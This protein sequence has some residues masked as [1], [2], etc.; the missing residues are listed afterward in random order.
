[1]GKQL[2]EEMVKDCLALYLKYGGERHDLIEQD[3]HRLGW[4]SFKKGM[5]GDRGNGENYRAGLVN[6][7]RWDLVLKKHLIDLAT[8]TVAATSAE[9]LLV[10][11]E[12]I[13]DAAFQEIKTLGVRAS[14]DLIYQ[15]NLYSQNCIKILDKLDAARDNYANFVFFLKHLL[16][17]APTISPSLTRELCDAEDALLDW[18][19]RQFVVEDERPDEL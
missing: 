3:M 13:R 8:N 19:E 16:S 10:E 17:A 4:S 11:A 1:M 12:F 5:L 14:K 2:N 15:H 18:A 9:K 6:K 7:F